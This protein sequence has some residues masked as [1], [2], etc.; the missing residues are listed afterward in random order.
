MSDRNTNFPENPEIKWIEIKI[1]DD[2][3]FYPDFPNYGA[4]KMA[5]PCPKMLSSRLFP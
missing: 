5:T 3:N 2:R 4:E 1:S